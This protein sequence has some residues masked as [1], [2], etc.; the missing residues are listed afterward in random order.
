MNDIISK[1][2]SRYLHTLYSLQPRRIRNPKNILHSTR[3]PLLQIRQRPLNPLQPILTH[4][5]RMP[6]KPVL[7]KPTTKI[8]QIHKPQIRI[9]IPRPRLPMDTPHTRLRHPER[10]RRDQRE[11]ILHRQH[12]SSPTLRMKHPQDIIRTTVCTDGIE[13]V[14]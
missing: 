7:S 13:G 11:L 2:Q 4:L 3:P 6:R 1:P 8:P 9:P 12:E 14:V 10:I 5:E